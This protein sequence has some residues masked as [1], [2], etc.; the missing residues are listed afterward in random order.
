[1]TIMFY[2]KSDQINRLNE[3]SLTKDV[4]AVTVFGMQAVSTRAFYSDKDT[5]MKLNFLTKIILLL[6][7]SADAKFTALIEQGNFQPSW[8]SVPVGYFGYLGTHVECINL[9]S[10]CFTV[11]AFANTCISLLCAST[12]VY[13]TLPFFCSVKPSIRSGL[14]LAICEDRP[15]CRV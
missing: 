15:W 14:R 3:L 8:R 7:C 10:V 1:M 2:P 9:H 13:F 11:A 6:N 4:A 5:W 12:F